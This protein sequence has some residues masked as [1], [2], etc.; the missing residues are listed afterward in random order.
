[1]L[2]C[3]VLSYVVQ[4]V[5]GDFFYIRQLHTIH[6]IVLHF[7]LFVLFFE[8]VLPS[9]MAPKPESDSSDVFMS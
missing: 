3:E 9:I 1:M 2:S 4:Y 7:L 5:E 6:S 8:N